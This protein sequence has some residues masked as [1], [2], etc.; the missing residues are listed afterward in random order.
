MAT[1]I[2]NIPKN[3]TEYPNSFKR[4]GAFPL[5]AYSVFSSLEAAITYAT[6]NAIAYVGQTLA[7]CED[8]KTTLYIIAD[9]AGNLTEVGSATDGDGYSI[10]L[11][12]GVLSISGFKAAAGATLPQ[13]QADGSLKWVAI[14]AIVEGDG[15]TK[16][17]VEVAEG[18]S[19]TVTPVY[20]EENDTYTYTLDVTLPEAYD[21]SE[22]RGR[23]ETLESELAN[24][25]VDIESRE[26]VEYIVIKGKDGEEITSV[27]ASKFVQDSF[28]ND[29]S[30]DPNSR[31]VTFT[32][33]MG[34]GSTKTDEIDVGDLVDTYTAGT[35]LTLSNNQFAVDTSV[36]ATVEA[37]NEKADK[38][39]TLSEY[40]ITNAY[41]KDEVDAKIGVPGKPE[42]KDAEGVIT[43]EKVDGTGIFAV[44]YS[45]DEINALLVEVEGGS[46]ESAASVA[47]DLNA[48][49][50]S[51]ND[52]V[53]SIEALVGVASNG[54]TPATGLHLLVSNAQESADAA[55]D[56][57]AALTTGAVKGNTDKLAG[58]DTTVIQYVSD[59]IGAI[60]TPKSSD[61]IDVSLNGTISITQVNVNKLVQTEGESLILDGGRA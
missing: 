42:L 53:S 49:K 59:A 54:E 48:Y 61:E 10:S 16:S 23:I 6:T 15:N 35:G 37:L 5:E 33:L 29:V 46:T 57:L 2:N 51:N 26:G 44:T 24:I 21:D 18:S 19:L 11:E 55:N 22:L 52:R 13:K 41:T 39:T 4:Q 27:N 45:K 30:Y 8:D 56:A 58:I 60:K 17:V 50:T 1:Y 28:L 20:N 3:L 47:R 7:V 40:G 12:D 36:I 31:K 38:A 34:D 32:W 25:S 43:Q 9:G 14:D